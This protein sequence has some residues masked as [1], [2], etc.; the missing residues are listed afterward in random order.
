MDAR[1][2]S[3]PARP[4]LAFDPRGARDVGG[5]LERPEELRG[6]LG[7]RDEP[8]GPRGARSRLS[9]VAPAVRAFGAELSERPDLLDRHRLRRKSRAPVCIALTPRVDRAE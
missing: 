9:S 5:A 4:E 1:A 7:P 6:G 2:R 3:R 8:R